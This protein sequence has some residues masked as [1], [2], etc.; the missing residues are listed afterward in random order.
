MQPLSEKFSLQWSNFRSNVCSA[1]QDLREDKDF[2]D[3]TLACE[4]GQQME[5]HKVILASASS[6][7]RNI[8]KT[9]KHT[10]PIIF[11][12]GLKSEDLV[13]VVDYIYK[14]EADVFQENLD[15]FLS[16]AKDLQ[17]KGL[18]QD[19]IETDGDNITENT[20]PK[21]EIVNPLEET[22]ISNPQSI[23]SDLAPKLS[24]AEIIQNVNSLMMFSENRA[25]GKTKGRG[26]KCKVCGKEGSMSSIIYHVEAKHMPGLA[27]PCDRCEKTFGSR[28]AFNAHD[29]TH[30]PEKAGKKM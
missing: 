12:R 27:I 7:F 19:Q 23:K 24:M 9:N 29:I 14:G 15:S 18:T 3:V 25:P 30:R 8:L 11:M 22:T 21:V 20:F 26:R 28:V 17:L 2:T 1:F 16:I 10:H 6:F 4:D 5:V 13:A